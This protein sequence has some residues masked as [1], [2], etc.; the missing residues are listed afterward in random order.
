M[1]RTSPFG[2]I[3]SRLCRVLALHVLRAAPGDGLAV[4]FGAKVYKLPLEHNLK[5]SAMIE[6]VAD[7]IR[8]GD[9]A[10]PAQP[11]P[12]GLPD[13]RL[14]RKEMT[15]LRGNWCDATLVAE[16][17][18]CDARETNRLLT[19]GGGGGGR[20][21]VLG[22]LCEEQDRTANFYGIKDNEELELVYMM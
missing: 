20:E 12:V 14:V 19:G 21:D 8:D 3:A 15:I 4:R 13:L 7:K 17:L 18:C 2:R 6:T 22:V 1:P 5:I 16:G 10:A 9:A 11:L